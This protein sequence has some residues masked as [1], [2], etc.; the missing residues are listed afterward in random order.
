MRDPYLENSIVLTTP[1]VIY[2]DVIIVGG[3]NPESEPAPPGDIR[4]FNVNTGTLKWSFHTIPHPGEPGYQT[5]NDNSYKKVGAANN[6]A[7][8]ALDETRGIVYVPTGPAAFDFYGGD[9]IGNNLYANCLLALDARTGKLLWH[10]QGVH[11]DLWDRDF[12]AHPVLLTVKHNGR[13]IDAVAQT[14]KQ[15]FLFVFDRTN[16]TPLFPIEEH[17]VPQTD[18]PGEVTSK[19]QPLPTYIAPFARQVLT[20]DILTDRTPEAHSWAV[21]EFRKLRSEGQLA[22]LELGRRTVMFPGFNGGGEWGGPGVD[23]TKGIMYINASDSPWTGGLQRIEGGDPGARIYQAQ[24]GT[25]HGQD[26]SGSSEFPASS[27]IFKRMNSTSIAE[28]VH[29]GKGRMPSFPSITEQQMAQLITFLKNGQATAITGPLPPEGIA[30]KAERRTRA[31]GTAEYAFTGYRKFEEPEGYPAVKPPWGSLNAIDLNTGKYL[32]KITLGEPELTAKG[33]P[34]T[35][36]ENYGGPVITAG[37]LVFIAATHYDRKI[38]S[39]P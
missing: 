23:P 19:T 20:E 16:G 37:G 27:G 12:S 8:M 31:S 13:N 5:W 21:Q 39:L 34:P 28:T 26:L 1:G 3:R 10:F 15:G 7:G 24:C 14:S 36:S 18:I 9:R 32:F 33:L 38:R 6:W 30:P 2:K 4:A 29:T 17:P 25:C 35:G 22:P 11:H